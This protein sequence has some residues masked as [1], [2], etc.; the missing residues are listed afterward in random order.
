[1]NSEDI[2]KFH[3]ELKFREILLSQ[4]RSAGVEID[5]IL[6]KIMEEQLTQIREKMWRSM[7]QVDVHPIVIYTKD[8]SQVNLFQFK[9]IPILELYF[10]WE[11]FV[12][13]TE[14]YKNIPEFSSE[15]K[16]FLNNVAQDIA[17]QINMGVKP[18]FNMDNFPI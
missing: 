11:A 8:P 17:N 14:N 2:K 7:Y 15:E 4:W 9:E 1:M 5:S 3:D 10:Y 13:D 18:H 12:P 16:R 6:L